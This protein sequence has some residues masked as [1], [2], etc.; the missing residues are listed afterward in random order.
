MDWDEFRVAQ[1]VFEKNRSYLYLGK[2][3]LLD[4]TL[5]NSKEVVLISPEKVEVKHPVLR[6]IE[7]LPEEVDLN[8]LPETIDCIVNLLPLKLPISFKVMAR[9]VKVL[10]TDGFVLVKLDIPKEQESYMEYILKDSLKD[11]GLV[12]VARINVSGDMFFIGKKA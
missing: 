8:Y 10:N 11:A 7:D 1:L 12:E 4:L 2:T 9:F 5:A 6:V 3:D